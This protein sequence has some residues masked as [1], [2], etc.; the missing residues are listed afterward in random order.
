MKQLITKVEI[1]VSELFEKNLPHHSL[2]KHLHH[3]CPEPEMK[4][5]R[6]GKCIHW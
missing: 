4:L 6:M 3:V 1:K 2:T 5:S